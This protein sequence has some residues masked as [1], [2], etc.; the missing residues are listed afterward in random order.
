M[1]IHM[2]DAKGVRSTDEGDDDISACAGICLI[3][4]AS[5]ATW[6]SVVGAF[7]VHDSADNGWLVSVAG[8]VVFAWSLV[9]L[10]RVGRL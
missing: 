7:M 5:V 6:V 9:R 4:I 3:C 1:T 8:L 10:G 2:R